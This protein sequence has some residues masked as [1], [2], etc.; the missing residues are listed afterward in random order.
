MLNVNPVNGPTITFEV[1]RSVPVIVNESGPTVVPVQT[2][3]PN[4]ARVV[5]DKEAEGGTWQMT[6]PQ[7]VAPAAHSL[8]F[9]NDPSVGSTAVPV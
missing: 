5:A 7:V 9:Q 6:V 2:A 4:A 3:L 8:K 1:L